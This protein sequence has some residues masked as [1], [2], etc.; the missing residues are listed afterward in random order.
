[1]SHLE[2]A[3]AIERILQADSLVVQ[4]EQEVFTAM[5]VVKAGRGSFADALIAALNAWAGAGSLSR[6]TRRLHGSHISS[7]SKSRSPLQ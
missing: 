1:M 7:L 2:I 6:S 4:N 5:T 3:T